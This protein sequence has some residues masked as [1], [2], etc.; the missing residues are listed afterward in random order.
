M[1]LDLTRLPAGLPVPQDDGACAHLVGLS[2][3]AIALGASGGGSVD[4]A[5][6]DGQSVVYVYP[7]TGQPGQQLPAGWD[8]IPGARGCTP[9]SLGFAEAAGQ[10]AQMGVRLFGLSTQKRSD[11]EEAVSRLQLPFLLLSDHQLRFANALRLPLFAVD[12]M[13]LIRRLTLVI[14]DGVVEHVFYP[15][16]P[17]DTHALTVLHWLKQQT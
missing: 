1:F 9:E 2:V 3:P 14:R 4:L 8:A 17:P 15:V 5:A 6:L 16:F 13:I 11:Q 12:Q 7:R 10:F